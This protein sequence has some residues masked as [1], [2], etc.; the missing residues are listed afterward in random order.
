LAFLF[1][2]NKKGKLV[3]RHKRNLVM[4]AAVMVRH[5]PFM[6]DAYVKKAQEAAQK[7]FAEKKD[8]HRKENA[9]TK[10]LHTAH[11]SFVGRDG[12]MAGSRAA[13]APFNRSYEATDMDNLLVVASR[14]RNV[15]AITRAKNKD[16]LQAAFAYRG[17]GFSS[18]NAKILAAADDAG[19]LPALPDNERRRGRDAL[20][21]VDTPLKKIR[22]VLSALGAARSTSWT[23]SLAASPMRLR[24]PATTQSSRL[25]ANGVVHTVDTMM[26]PSAAGRREEAAVSEPNVASLVDALGVF[27]LITERYTIKDNAVNLGLEKKVLLEE[28]ISWAV[29]VDA[30]TPVSDLLGIFWGTMQDAKQWT[31]GH[32]RSLDI[33]FRYCREATA[34]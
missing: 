32:K 28:G 18:S 10:A 8:D 1:Q 15:T 25:V 27:G 20:L 29:V 9:A 16:K 22:T 14:Q 31:L 17:V 7:R 6:T 19:G 3:F 24:A 21:G 34:L 13:G 11:P 12:A 23:L 4:S 5:S 26:A 2:A 30:G 33:F